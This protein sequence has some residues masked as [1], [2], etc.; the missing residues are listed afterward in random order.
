[1]LYYATFI[2]FH[3]KFHVPEHAFLDFFKKLGCYLYDLLDVPGQDPGQDTTKIPSCDLQEVKNAF[4]NF[5]SS[6][7]PEIVIVVIKRIYREI[8][9]LLLELRRQGVIEKYFAL[10]FPGRARTSTRYVDE[11]YNII[12]ET[13]GTRS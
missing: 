13:I 7:K 9:D 6:E 4:R 8:K 3:K 5:I 12:V 11:L 10:P 1:M 2:A